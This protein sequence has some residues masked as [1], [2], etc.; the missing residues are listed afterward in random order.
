MKILKNLWRGIKNAQLEFWKDAKKSWKFS[1][2]FVLCVMG[3][4]YVTGL[5]PD[6]IFIRISMGFAVF[7]LCYIIY[8]L[9]SWLLSKKNKS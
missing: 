6:L 3:L 5:T 8:F 4:S 2:V 7:T 9:L 1:F